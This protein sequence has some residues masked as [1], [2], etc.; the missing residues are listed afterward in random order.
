[1]SPLWQ[2]KSVESC[3]VLSVLKCDI[4]LSS[5]VHHAIEVVKCM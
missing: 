3:I 1:M 4:T 2:G 5:A